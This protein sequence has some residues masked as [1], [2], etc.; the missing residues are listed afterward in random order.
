MNRMHQHS[1]NPLTAQEQLVADGLARQRA[2]DRLASFIVDAPAGAGKTELLTQRFLVLLARVNEPEEVVALTF[3]RKAAAE[4]RDRIMASLR[5]ATQPLPTE[6]PPHKQVTHQLALNVLKQNNLREWRLLDQPGRL[7]VMTL[8]ALAMS[9]ARQ[10]PLLSRFGTQPGLSTECKPLYEQA[11]RDTLSLLETAASEDDQDTV[12]RVLAYFDNDSSRLQK[13]LVAMLERRDQWQKFTHSGQSKQLQQAVSHV[14]ARLIASELADIAGPLGRVFDAPVMSAARHAA[15]NSP[16]SPVHLLADWAAPLPTTADALPRWRALAE[17][18]LTGDNKLRKDY[19]APINLAG[20]ANKEQKQTLKD[21]LATLGAAELGPLLAR[22]REL[23]DPTLGHDEAAIVQ[24]LARLLQLAYGNLWLTFI[25]EKTV[26]HTEISSR[27]LAALGDAEQPTDLAQ[28]LDYQIQHLLVD[29]FQD[30][31]PTQVELLE[32][33]TAG[34]SP[35]SGQTLFLVGDPMQ[36]IYRFRKADVGLFIRVRQHGIGPIAPISLQLYQNNRSNENIVAWVNHTFDQVFADQDDATR[37]AVC[38]SPAVAKKPHLDDAGVSIHPVIS[39]DRDP[40]SGEEAPRSLVDQREAEI[41]LQLIRDARNE[42]PAGTVAVLV[43]ARSHLDA[44]VALLQAQDAPILFQAVEIDALAARQSIQDLVALTRALHHQG[45][46]LHWLAILR[47]PWDGLCLADLHQ[48]AAHDHAQTLW[49][50][51]QD[52]T[53]IS[54]LSEDGQH[55]LRRLRQILAEAYAARS[56]Q[57]P[58]RWIEGIWRALGGPQCLSAA[59][60]IADVQ[61]YF[62]LLDTLDHHGTLDLSL[63][64]DGL[65]R[66]FAAPEASPE[67]Q[68]VQLMTVHKS[69]GL[70]F[71]TV[72]LP[73]LH[74]RLPSDDKALIIWDTVLLDDDHEHLVVAPVPPI[75]AAKSTTPTAYDLLRNLEKTR[76]LNEA[77]RVLYVAVTRAERRLHLLGAA[78]RDPKDETGQT[79]KAPAATSLLAPLWPC[80]EATFSAA[81]ALPTAPLPRASSIDPAQFVPRLI[82][83]ASAHLTEPAPLSLTS[84]TADTSDQPIMQSPLEPVSESTLDMAIG[85]LVHRYLE[86]IALD[87]LETWH[88]ERINL[89]LPHFERTFHREGHDLASSQTAARQV[90]AAILGALNSEHGRWIL[91]PREAASC[92]VPMSSLHPDTPDAFSHHVIDRTFI[93]AGTRWIIDYKTLRTVDEGAAPDAVLQEKAAAYKAQLERYA[94]LFA[95]EGLPIRTAIFFPAHGK[96]VEI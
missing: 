35:D 74:K 66:L 41:I 52:D 7:R 38:F 45:D 65:G 58:R 88:E 57:R 81:A 62:R 51:M 2:L 42:R 31:S 85:N 44:L 11:A 48:L 61:A 14:L 22:I 78:Y 27:A 79:L 75:G 60:D 96:L 25:Q 33:L 80:L 34:W 50:L 84:L 87:G 93:E 16:D 24:D 3:T 92:E 46:R 37:G 76:S 30:T 40:E 10:M 13:M 26:D 55:R 28:Q 83:L 64:D 39:G 43:R 15:A 89:L 18:F 23:P 12:A 56:L 63:L 53:H 8:D 54:H 1:K 5:A 70:Q 6:T 59:S 68:H 21:A 73:G 17:L 19:R 71:D 86:A 47:A 94:A 49:S 95:T 82:R 29:E 4:M 69:K 90:Q 72:I 36:S 67:S 32:K 9:L 20:P 77:Q 91:G